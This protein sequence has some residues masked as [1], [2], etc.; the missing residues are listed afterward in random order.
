MTEPCPSRVSARTRTPIAAADQGVYLKRLHSKKKARAGYA[1]NVT[2]KI[3]EIREL[4]G[5]DQNLQTV[6][7]ELVHAVITF[8]KFRLLVL[9]KGYRSHRGMSQLFDETRKRL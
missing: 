2:T 7:D 6:K 9:S 8:N 3:R 1:S 4:L 5:D